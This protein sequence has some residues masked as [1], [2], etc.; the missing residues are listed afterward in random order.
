MDTMCYKEI[1]EV[2]EEIAKFKI[3][4]EEHTNSYGSFKS[5][6]LVFVSVSTLKCF[7]L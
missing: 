4:Y 5:C 3:E 7:S 6:S 2:I 1:E